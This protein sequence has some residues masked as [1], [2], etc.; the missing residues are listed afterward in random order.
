MNFFKRSKK[1]EEQITDPQRFFKINHIKVSNH[2]PP[3]D[4]TIPEPTAED[5]AWAKDFY[6]QDPSIHADFADIY[7][8]EKN[9]WRLQF[10]LTAVDTAYAG[11]HS[12]LKQKLLTQMKD[13]SKERMMLALSCIQPTA[14][15]LAKIMETCPAETAAAIAKTYQT[16]LTP[17][18]Q[19][20]KPAMVAMT[21][22]DYIIQ[23][24]SP[25][26]Q[27]DGGNISYQASRFLDY[28]TGATVPVKNTAS[29]I[30]ESKKHKL[31]LLKRA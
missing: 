28:Q 23:T 4:I 26:T 11:L 6:K 13:Q 18:A 22:H 29:E 30:A 2:Q 17:N 25:A 24:I 9:L 19:P 8:N 5:L 20:E 27:M 7:A 3:A 1:Q 12:V 31:P 15:T 10:I 14:T 21:A 16:T